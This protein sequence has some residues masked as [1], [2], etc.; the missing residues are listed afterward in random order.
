MMSIDYR[1]LRARL[2]IQDV[3]HWMN[4]RAIRQGGD[5]LRGRCPLCSASAKDQTSSN[6]SSGSVHRTFSVHTQRNLYRCFRCHSS[7]NALDLWAAYRQLPIYDAAKEIQIR[8][9]GNK[10]P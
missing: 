3:L 7:G 4:W 6:T 1:E 8:L 9:D 5:Q 2:R 10:Q